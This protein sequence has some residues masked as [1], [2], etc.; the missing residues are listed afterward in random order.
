MADNLLES[1]NPLYDVHLRQYFALPH[2]QK[3]LRNVG[4]LENQKGDEAPDNELYARHHAMMDMLLRNRERVLHQLADLHKKLDAAE[5]VEICRRIRSGITNAEEFRRSHMSRSLSRPA[6]GRSKRSAG[7]H[8]RRY[9]NSFE[10]GEMIKRIESGSRTEND[11]QQSRNIYNRLAASVYKYQYLHKLDDRT[12]L[13]YMQSLRKQL[14]KL[15]RF[16]EL[17][18]GPH[19]V[20]RHQPSLQNSWFFRRRSLP[21][22]T[23]SAPPNTLH[24]PL[25]SIKSLRKAR[26]G[27][28]QSPRKF[29]PAEGQSASTSAKSR[30][31][32]YAALSRSR[33]PPQGQR[34]PPLPKPTKP[35]QRPTAAR[36]GEAV[37][38]LPPTAMIKPTV[39]QAK[40]QTPPASAVSAISPK[41]K[42]S[43]V[44][45]SPVEN[46]V[47]SPPPSVAGVTAS[48]LP[49]IGG[50]AAGAAIAAALTSTGDQN[51]T[52]E[53]VEENSVE[54]RQSP[55]ESTGMAPSEESL[56]FK[57]ERFIRSTEQGEIQSG[58]DYDGNGS[59]AYGD[60]ETRPTPEPF[61][62]E[63]NLAKNEI[64]ISSSPQQ[65]ESS[66]PPAAESPVQHDEA[67]LFKESHIEPSQSATPEAQEVKQETEE[68]SPRQD[69][70]EERVES[71]PQHEAGEVN[72]TEQHYDEEEDEHAPIE[73][74]HHEEQAIE[75]PGEENNDFVESGSID[76]YQ[77]GHEHGPEEAVSPLEP[78]AA[79]PVKLH[80][81][82]QEEEHRA[83]FGDEH[84]EGE[85]HVADR[86][87]GIESQTAA[88]L[89][90]TPKY[91][92]RLEGLGHSSDE[93]RTP[94]LIIEETPSP[95]GSDHSDEEEEIHTHSNVKREAPPQE[96]EAED[97]NGNVKEHHEEE[98]AETSPSPR[99]TD[100][101]SQHDEK[102]EAR[103]GIVE[104]R[105]SEA[106]ESHTN[107]S[108]K[109][110][111]PWEDRQN[112]TPLQSGRDEDEH[113]YEEDHR[114][115]GSIADDKPESYRSKRSV[116]EQ[117][118]QPEEHYEDNTVEQYQPSRFEQD[119]D[120]NVEHRI[121]D[122][123][124]EEITGMEDKHA[125]YEA[126]LL[127]EQP[128]RD[129]HE[130]FGVE[131]KDMS[132]YDEDGDERMPSAHDTIEQPYST[133]TYEESQHEMEDRDVSEGQEAEYTETHGRKSFENESQQEYGRES[134]GLEAEDAEQIRQV[135]H[136]HPETEEPPP[137]SVRSLAGSEPSA[138]SGF[139]NG[140]EKNEEDIESR[141]GEVHM[142]DRRESN[143][144][145][146][147][148]SVKAESV[149][150]SYPHE[151][152]EADSLE[153]EA[154]NEVPHEVGHSEIDRE[155]VKAEFVVQE[156]EHTDG[157]SVQIPAEGD[158]ESHES[159]HDEPSTTYH[160]KEY[161][162]QEPIEIIHNSDRE[163]GNH[164]EMV[165]DEE[166]CFIGGASDHP[167]HVFSPSAMSHEE[168]IQEH[169]TADAIDIPELLQPE[170]ATT[171]LTNEEELFYDDHEYKEPVPEAD[172]QEE[173]D[174]DKVEH[175]D[176]S[177]L[178]GQQHEAEEN[179][180]SGINHQE[181][182][183][184]HMDQE[185]RYASPE[186][187]SQPRSESAADNQSEAGSQFSEHERVSHTASSDGPQR[188][189]HLMNHPSIEIT[190]ASDYGGSLEENMNRSPTAS[191]GQSTVNHTEPEQHHDEEHVQ[192]HTEEHSAHNESD[193][194]PVE[195]NH[196][197]AIYSTSVT[198]NG[199]NP[200]TDQ[201][202]GIDYQ[203]SP[204]V[205]NNGFDDHHRE[206]KNGEESDEET[207]EKT[208]LL[209]NDYSNGGNVTELYIRQ[210]R[211]KGTE[212][213][214]SEE[215]DSG[216]VI[217]HNEHAEETGGNQL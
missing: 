31:R 63:A 62:E 204:S 216:S 124:P 56:P 65:A 39:Q 18:F 5:K 86:Q 185:T 208:G 3:H 150:D 20:A 50:V 21:S 192:Y 89:D 106:H 119:E 4:L 32:P 129:A 78:R 51:E 188:G 186:Q 103:E 41:G 92:L 25:R 95:R 144:F 109:E 176:E 211:G 162:S 198:E 206:Q 142:E 46:N 28:S 163:E 15:E 195:S 79:S 181:E 210:K 214:N 35:F 6:R 112:E 145:G 49:A 209:G 153:D 1:Y 151:Q 118:E 7:E 107:E 116:E 183:V 87:T 81:E 53:H 61:L 175:E 10:D 191:S 33:P 122:H 38:K 161:E 27:K 105:Q 113:K 121:D 2:M 139:N 29:S 114:E 146:E 159:A 85:S 12:L 167:D 130:N 40:R 152:Y 98:Q 77:L 187:P 44:T 14:Q 67:E 90:E 166:K 72:V 102:P 84:N 76:H 55:V 97:I 64:E 58:S 104:S 172:H 37:P 182:F 155:S 164:T 178:S 19:S 138:A 71:S 190:P 115:A 201:E 16:R 91:S 135:V 69:Y 184:Q 96:N 47:R 154:P 193:H 83:I 169:D 99:D 88:S 160:E 148:E 117:Y 157:N 43:S 140:V 203:H 57:H 101:E 149:H 189:I 34:L 9:S 66:P 36:S 197:E 141:N 108:G 110:Q 128:I 125:D 17:S 200:N 68:H 137:E 100:I 127:N 23:S 120:V 202:N 147:Q 13:K 123:H 194:S 179:T 207:D 26:S 212:S 11:A 196:T 93:Q 8:Q 136:P 70:E 74:N 168:N 143:H 111:D 42:A 177:S 30:P 165:C 82:E 170:S 132:N 180:G 158:D 60:T 213:D 199:K 126:S 94:T 173:N 80:S 73:H 171:E 22:L 52:A 217:I 134:V 131:S 174:L 59:A 48:V 215:E 156:A 133:R 45:P 205:G 75:S 24:Q 54:D